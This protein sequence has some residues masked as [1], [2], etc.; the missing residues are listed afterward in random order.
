MHFTYYAEV[1][2]RHYEVSAYQ[3]RPG[4]FAAIFLNI[5]DQKQAEEAL[6]KS[7]KRYRMLFTNMTDGFGLIDVI[8]D[9]DGRPYDYRY[10]DVN[11]AFEF[12]LGV[13]REQMLGRTILEIFPNVGPIVIE[14]F[15]EVALPCMN[16]M[17]LQETRRVLLALEIL[18]SVHI[19]G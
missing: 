13:N 2:R 1:Q 19:D 17:D 4:R 3:I 5:T 15:T 7:E 16:M 8:Y 14:K 11:P 9:M 12:S 10:L 18:E 6:R